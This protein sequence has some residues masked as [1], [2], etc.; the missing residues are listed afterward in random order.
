[1]KQADSPSPA[2]FNPVL[3]PVKKPIILKCPA[4]VNWFLN[5]V[6]KR[7]DGYHDIVS[8]MQCVSLCDE[9]VLE[10]SN[11]IDIRCNLNIPVQDNLV[12]QAANLLQKYSS[13]R[14]G[15]KIFLNKNIPVGAGLGG[16]SSDAAYALLGLNKL[17]GLGLR[18]TELSRMGSLLGSDIPFFFKGPAALVEGKGEQVKPMNIR[19]RF[20]LLLVKPPV[21]VSTTWAYSLHDRLDDRKLTKKAVDIKLFCQVLDRQDYE[22]LSNICFN[23][24]E[25]VVSREY[26]A[27]NEIKKELLRIGA[28]A[29]AMS[30]SGPSVF[31]VFRKN[32]DAE[33]AARAMKPNWCRVVETLI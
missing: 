24:F 21:S 1:V 12:Y 15:A 25:G 19:S 27:V 33:V 32:E 6:G 20:A 16:G 18:N 31:G 7:K 2:I 3:R 14:K 5:I 29:A 23:D 11:T 28:K 13:Y 8:L 17:W 9:I 10:H 26:P 4:K 30:G 22:C